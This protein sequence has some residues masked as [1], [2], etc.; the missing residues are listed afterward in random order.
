[1]L[2]AILLLQIKTQKEYFIFMK[3]FTAILLAA[4]CALSLA[5][6]GSQ[7]PSLN[8]VENAIKDGSMTV[9]DALDKGWVTQEWADEYEQQQ[10]VPAA[11]KTEAGAIGEFTTMTLSGEEFTREQM[12]DVTL[13]AFLDPTDPD[14]ETFYQALADGYEGVK[15]NGAEI[16]VCTKSQD[17][18]ELF[19]DAPFPVIY[20]NDSLKNA[21]ENYKEMI[22]GMA[23]TACWC[24]NASFLSAWS[25]AVESEKLADSATSFVEM[26]KEMDD[27]NGENNGMA[28]MG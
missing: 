8:E 26:K 2:Y 7:K 16:L 27:D 9:Q 23:N 18:N 13:F 1:M 14:A 22:E 25:S 4:V 10:S 19:K 3:R 5:A 17:G 21:T 24:V 28:V 20:Y 6:C 11:S 15:E 12:A